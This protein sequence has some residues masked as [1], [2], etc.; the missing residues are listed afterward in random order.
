MEE[1]M[2]DS[3]LWRN[4]NFGVIGYRKNTKKRKK[5]EKENDFFIF[6]CLIKNIIENQ[7]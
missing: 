3:H 6:G 5:N 2:S 7:I 4:S 1:E